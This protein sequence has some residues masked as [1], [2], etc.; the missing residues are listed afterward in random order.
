MNE[1]VISRNEERISS[2]TAT[3]KAG[4]SIAK[5]LIGFLTS[6]GVKN[7]TIDELIE[8][9]KR[10][11]KTPNL[12]TIKR[13]VQ[14]L[15][16][17]NVKEPNVQGI[18]IDKEKLIDMVQ[19]KEDIEPLAKLLQRSHGI[20]ENSRLI[21]TCIVICN[22]G[23]VEISPKAQKIIE[24]RNTSKASTPNQLKALELVTQ[25]IDVI[26]NIEQLAQN[27]G[28]G[29]EKGLDSPLHQLPYIKLKNGKVLSP[30]SDYILMF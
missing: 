20:F 25:L 18:P 14:E 28:V 13:W 10:Y 11:F 5:E 29:I 27:R 4:A 3:V 24:A 15:L 21:K 8:G 6:Q 30:S 16:V 12:D 9:S 23:E 17:K 19:L 7:P 1:K 26:N 22:N 2:D